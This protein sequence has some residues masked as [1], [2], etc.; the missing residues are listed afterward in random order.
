[1]LRMLVFVQ[2]ALT[3]DRDTNRGRWGSNSVHTG[4]VFPYKQ[5]KIS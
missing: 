4:S 1:M 5:V 2:Q 3:E